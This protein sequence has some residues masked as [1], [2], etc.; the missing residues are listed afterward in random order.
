[1]QAHEWSAPF[2]FDLRPKIDRR[3]ASEFGARHLAFMKAAGE[4]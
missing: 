1:M 2:E 3:S 4:S